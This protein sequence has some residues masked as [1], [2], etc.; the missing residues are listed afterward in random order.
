VG[1]SGGTPDGAAEQAE[2][3]HEHPFVARSFRSILTWLWL[4]RAI[5]KESPMRV[6]KTRFLIATALL[7]AVI[8]ET[9]PVHAAPPIPNIQVSR[10]HYA[11]HAEPSLAVNPRDPRN[12][13][14]AAYLLPA[15]HTF[16]RGRLPGTFVSFDGGATWRDNGPLPLPSGY[17]NGSNVSVAYTTQGIGYVVVRVDSGPNHTG[18]FVWRT[19]D[20]GRHFLPP[21]RLA[22]G[23][24]PTINVD[25]PWIAAAPSGSS[26]AGAVYVAWSVTTSRRSDIAFSRSD[27]H[28][29]SF[30]APRLVT[31]P[32]PQ[33]DVA[34]VITAG[35]GGRVAVVYADLPT[36]GAGTDS[37]VNVQQVQIRVVSSTDGGRHFEP[38]RYVAPATLGVAS[39]RPLPL[40]GLPTAVTDLRDGSLYVCFT[41]DRPS[42]S[43][44]NI[45]LMRSGDGG[46]TWAALRR[47]TNDSLTD[48][49][50]RLQPQLAVSVDGTVAVSYLALHHGR[51]DLYLA[52]SYDHGASFQPAVR[53]TSQSWDP[54]LGLSI[55]NGQF[56]VGDYQGLAAGPTTIYPFWND[57]RTG[58][59]EIFTAAIPM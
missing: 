13:L 21:A 59:L 17:S 50:D 39:N 31:G 57:T 6:I 2:Q 33:A 56:W 26:D 1:I 36:S 48:Q 42:T 20:G 44:P 52:R 38:P 11:A 22:G 16:D 58:R 46:R 29:R 3:R 18:I 9:P 28:G 51:L 23:G 27:N 4:L 53:V 47:V 8:G 45:V 32:A 14:G 41:R 54:T 12:L 10:D 40:F 35:P 34:P 43:H 37:S 15:T 49:M 55:G 24:D 25:H 30:T 19:T 5:T 7:L